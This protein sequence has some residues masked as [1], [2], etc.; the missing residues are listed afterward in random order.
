ML[1]EISQKRLEKLQGEY[2]ELGRDICF[3]SSYYKYTCGKCERTIKVIDEMH[4][5]RNSGTP[6]DD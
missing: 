2:N 1:D 4:K 5:I 6:E 3:C